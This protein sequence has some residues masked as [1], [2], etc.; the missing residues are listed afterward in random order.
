[1]PVASR[2]RGGCPKRY[3]FRFGRSGAAPSPRGLHP[4]QGEGR[5]HTCFFPRCPTPSSALLHAQVKVQEV[6]EVLPGS[7]QQ[8]TPPQPKSSTRERSPPLV[9]EDPSARQPPAGGDLSRAPDLKVHRC[10]RLSIAR[11]ASRSP[12]SPRV[13][14]VGPIGGAVVICAFLAREELC[15]ARRPCPGPWL[16]PSPTT[17]QS[18]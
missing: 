10:S 9:S 16:S 14:P 8:I 12:W 2:G 13:R 18:S 7:R 11:L 4:A 5:R 1:M 15:Q 17:A 6:R 3:G